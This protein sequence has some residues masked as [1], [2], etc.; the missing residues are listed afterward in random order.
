MAAGVFVIR[1]RQCVLLG[2]VSRAGQMMQGYGGGNVMA[3]PDLRSPAHGMGGGKGLG[4]MLL[5]HYEDLGQH[6]AIEPNLHQTMQFSPIQ[7]S[8]IYCIYCICCKLPLC[9]CSM[10]PCKCICI[11]MKA[12]KL[13]VC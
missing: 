4:A 8:F 6:T 9:I 2:G 7:R 5:C 3:T 12:S 11:R 13:L 10:Q 1:A